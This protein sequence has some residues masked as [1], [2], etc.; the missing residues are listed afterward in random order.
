MRNLGGQTKS[1][2][3]FLQVIYHPPRLFLR[4]KRSPVYEKWKDVLTFYIET[5][6]KL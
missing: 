3:V 2:V 4:G 6:I 1:I 5:I